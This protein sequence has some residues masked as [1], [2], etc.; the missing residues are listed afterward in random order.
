[1]AGLPPCFPFIVWTLSMFSCKRLSMHMCVWYE[2][3]GMCSR[4]WASLV[5]AGM[6]VVSPGTYTWRSYSWNKVFGF[7]RIFR[8]WKHVLRIC[9][10][11][12]QIFYYLLLYMCSQ[13]WKLFISGSKHIR[14]GR[15]EGCKDGVPGGGV[16]G[17]PGE[18]LLADV[19]DIHKCNRQ[20]HSY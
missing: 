11:R 5:C 12:S 15:A 8:W 17:E 1:M 13:C 6:V 3:H 16:W 2:V 20:R 19:G 10:R 18:D 14:G 9:S 4:F 7:F